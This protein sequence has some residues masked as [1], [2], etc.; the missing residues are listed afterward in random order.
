MED[1]EVKQVVCEELCVTKLYVK[2]GVRQRKRCMWQSFVCKIV[3]VKVVCERW[4]VTKRCV[5][6]GVWQKNNVQG[7][8]MPCRVIKACHLQLWL[9]TTK[10]HCWI[11]KWKP[12][13]RCHKCHTC[14]AKGRQMSPS[15]TPARQNAGGCH[16]A[17]CHAKRRQM[18][19]SATL[20]AR[21][22]SGCLQVPRLPRKAGRRHRRPS[23]PKRATRASPVR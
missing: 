23:A 3:C 1:Q 7:P 14:Y 13:T 17:P 12:P 21:N 4:C 19:P 6:D 9:H 5:K 16:E 2:D 20:I 22:E 18:S 8:K 15:A 11:R 10:L